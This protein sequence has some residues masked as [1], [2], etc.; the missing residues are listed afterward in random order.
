MTLDLFFILKV[1]II[2]YTLLQNVVTKD[3]CASRIDSEGLQCFSFNIYN[4]IKGLK[5]FDMF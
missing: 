3:P 5:H 1:E 4:P 2:I